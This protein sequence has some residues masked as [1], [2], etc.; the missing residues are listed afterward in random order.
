MWLDGKLEIT[1]LVF[2]PAVLSLLFTEHMNGIMERIIKLLL[3]PFYYVILRKCP[4][5]T[6]NLYYWDSNN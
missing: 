3:T 5:A 2:I 4:E 1:P 6:V